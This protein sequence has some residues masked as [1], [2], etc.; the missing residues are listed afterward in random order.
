MYMY[1]YMYVQLYMCTF[2]SKPV[3]L[4]TRKLLSKLLRLFSISLL[5][6]PSLFSM[7]H[8]HSWDKFCNLSAQLIA[9][10]ELSPAVVCSSPGAHTHFS[11]LE[12]SREPSKMTR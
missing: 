3:R 9:L 12:T 4:L 2:S 8:L 10:Y 11:S 1:V 7:M 6:F 5:M